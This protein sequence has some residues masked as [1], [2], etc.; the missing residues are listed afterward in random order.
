MTE[1]NLDTVSNSTWSLNNLL[2]NLTKEKLIYLAIFVV[3]VAAIVFYLKYVRNSE[4]LELL[5]Q[6]QVPM[7]Y[8]QPNMM[9]LQPQQPPQPPPQPPQPQQMEYPKKIVMDM[10]LVEE[11]KTKNM[12]PHDYIFELQRAG[13]FPPGPMPEIVIDNKQVRNVVQTEKVN[14]EPKKENNLNDLKLEDDEEESDD[15][16]DD[17]LKDEDLSKEEMDNIRDQLLKLQKPSSK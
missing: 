4:K 12:S 7:M 11:L 10:E 1:N 6:Q 14:V 5:P 13:Q 2:N 16:E 8:Q 17:N 9:P 3:L 15:D